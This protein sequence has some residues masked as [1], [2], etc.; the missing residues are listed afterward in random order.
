M[1]IVK[2]EPEIR[3]ALYTMGLGK[4]TGYCFGS[5]TINQ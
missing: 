3:E 5:V 1:A 4:S 2:G